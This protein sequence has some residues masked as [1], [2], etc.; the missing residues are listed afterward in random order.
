VNAFELEQGDLVFFQPKEGGIGGIPGFVEAVNGEA[1]ELLFPSSLYKES[2][3]R[4]CFLR[5]ISFYHDVVPTYWARGT[6]V[7]A[8]R[9]VTFEPPLFLLFPAIVENTHYDVCVELDF[10]SGGDRLAPIT[11]VEKPALE[12][13][14]I[15]FTC[16]SF[17]SHGINPEERWSPCRIIQCNGHT[18]V[19]QDGTGEQF[20]SDISMIATLPKGYQMFDGKFEK[21]QDRRPDPPRRPATESSAFGN[22]HIVRADTWQNAAEDPITRAQVDDLIGRDPELAWAPDRESCSILWEGRPAFWWDRYEIRC[23]MPTEDE[24]AKMI[25]IAIELDANVVRD[26][27]TELH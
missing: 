23:A 4:K 19:L 18:L 11:L 14:D 26:D 6:R 12:P 22:V 21:V 13:G 1:V 17:V 24:L 7:F 25:A 16:T 15:V 9:P 20:E 8:Y 10:G 2:E 3:R 27:G 5:E